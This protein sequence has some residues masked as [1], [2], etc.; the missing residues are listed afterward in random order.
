MMKSTPI[1]LTACTLLIPAMAA[2]RK[3]SPPPP[4][5]MPTVSSVLAATSIT[6]TAT[7]TASPAPGYQP[8]DMKLL[9]VGVD[10][11]EPS[12]QA[13][14]FFLDYLGIPY[15][16]VLARTQPLP[17]LFTA[18]KGLYQGIILSTGNL[19]YCAN[20]T[21]ASALSASDWAALDS[22]TQ[23][24][25]VRLAT[26]YAWPEKRYGVTAKSALGTSDAAPATAAFTSA[27]A[28]VFPYLT[29]ANG[30][31][32]ANA[33][34][35]LAAASPDPGETVTPLL[36]IQ[37]SPVAVLDTKA[38]GREYL[39]MTLDHNPYLLHSMAL[40]Y[41]VFNWVTKG[42]FLGARKIYFSPQMDDFFL[43]NDLFVKNV[44]GCMPSGFMLDP[45][46]DPGVNCPTARMSQGDLD[47]LAYWQFALDF[48]PQFRN[49]TVGLAFNGYG[50]GLGGGDY[51]ATDALTRDAQLRRGSFFWVNHTFDH[52]D[53]DCYAPVANT[54]ICTPAT[55]AQSLAE[56][57]KNV[58]IA[59]QL[60]LPLDS[61]SMV[62]PAISGLYNPAFLA[63]ARQSGIKYL[64]GDTSRVDGLPAKPN[65]GIVSG[66]EPSILIIP[67]RPVNV[68]Y[69]TS[70][71]F[72]GA[73]GSLVDEY[74]YFY[75]PGGLFQKP[76]GTPY[77]NA[78]QTL[79]DIVNRESD[80]LLAYMMRYEIYPSM[81]HQSNF[82]RYSGGS[83]LFTDVANATLTKFARLSNLPVV[84]LQQ[85]DIGRYMAERMAFNAS[86]ATATWTPGSNIT[87]ATQGATSVRLT[88]VCST[89]CEL[90]GGQ[91][92][93]KVAIPANGTVVIP[94]Y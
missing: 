25:K 3:T 84:S 53:L 13:I 34:V 64:V 16:A 8:R 46:Y 60:G 90:Y 9:V 68:F 17:P 65:T 38:D 87:I 6:P 2:T 93:S 44:A 14:T 55:Q 89:A 56:I 26:F 12:Y 27:G 11:T 15:Q 94:V 52:E 49:I 73:N 33:Y 41:G 79:A 69:N 35:Y 74:N 71:G 88:G 91:Y 43:A 80:N 75:A 72:A 30:L 67:R 19:A 32:V 22:Y 86:G 29:T 24:Y 23:A 7:T 58:T 82:V 28:Q 48:N 4:V 5:Q 50:S 78:P 81:W 57:S 37:G 77:F 45:T 85:S 51:P 40:N 18:S 10:G 59:R 47:T 54:G 62:T 20:G 42:M 70:S 66:I 76:D 61:T 83:S 21:C 63:A 92:Q 31:K 1:L 36:T 39:A